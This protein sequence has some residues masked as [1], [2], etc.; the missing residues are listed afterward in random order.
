MVFTNKQNRHI[1]KCSKNSKKIE[2]DKNDTILEEKTVKERE[3]ILSEYNSATCC[4]KRFK[5][6]VKAKNEQNVYLIEYYE[7]KMYRKLKLESYGNQQ[8]VKETM[9]KK[10]ANKFGTKDE[11]VIMMGDWSETKQMK[12]CDPSKGKGIRRIFKEYGYELYI[13]DE[14]RTSCRLYETGEELINMRNEHKL[15]GSK[16]YNKVQDMD[17]LCIKIKEEIKRTGKRPTIINM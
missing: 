5:E 10:F 12:N 7:K 9:I 6:Y 14:Y 1:L 4:I 15:L 13:V 17:I 16:I 11:V 8:R 2:R 3:T